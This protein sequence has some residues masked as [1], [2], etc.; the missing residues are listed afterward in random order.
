MAEDLDWSPLRDRLIWIAQFCRDNPSWA[1]PHIVP[2]G[3]KLKF[4]GAFETYQ[5][6]VSWAEIEQCRINPFPALVEIAEN[7]VKDPS[8]RRMS[9]ERF[10]PTRG[11]QAFVSDN[12]KDDGNG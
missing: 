12:E 11:M 6:V 9:A 5:R 8:A 3:V 10:S 1:E 7:R 2:E 4:R